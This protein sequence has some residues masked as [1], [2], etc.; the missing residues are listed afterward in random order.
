MHIQILIWHILS[1]ELFNFLETVFNS[2]LNLYIQLGFWTWYVNFK[3]ILHSCIFWQEKSVIM[4]TFWIASMRFILAHREYNFVFQQRTC[5]F[6]LYYKVHTMQQNDLLLFAHFAI[7][8][9]LKKKVAHTNLILYQKILW[10]F[11]GRKITIDTWT[12]YVKNVRK[13]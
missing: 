3:K 12:I 13:N 10:T 8:F 4:D 6:F 2:K 7:H 1:Y 5:Y 11:H 9:M